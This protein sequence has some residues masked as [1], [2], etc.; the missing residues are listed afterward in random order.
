MGS[1]SNENGASSP[2]EKYPYPTEFNVLD[3]VPKLFSEGNY[4]NWKLLMQDFIRMRG[5]IGFIEG[6]AA[7][8]LNGDEAWNRSNNLVRGW[9]LVTL[10]EDI[11]PQ[12]LS[13][14][15]AKDL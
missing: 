7:E 8:E 14:E 12:V 6:T 4:N 1:S 15:S 11:R 3:F 5:L 2:R 10:S 9:I 13:L